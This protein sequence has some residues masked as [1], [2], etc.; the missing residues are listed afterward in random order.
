MVQTCSHVRSE[1][2]RTRA[3][4]PV[5]CATADGGGVPGVAGAVVVGVVTGLPL[6]A[7]CREDDPLLPPIRLTAARMQMATSATAMAAA[8]LARFGSEWATW[9]STEAPGTSAGCGT[10]SSEWARSNSATSGT[11]SMSRT[12]EMLRM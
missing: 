6:L 1:T 10:P 4:A 7:V 8:Q 5:S 9:G 2:T 11:G 3:V 12:R